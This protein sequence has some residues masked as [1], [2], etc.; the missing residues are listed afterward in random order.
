MNKIYNEITVFVGGGSF[1]KDTAVQVCGLSHFPKC[2]QMTILFFRASWLSLELRTWP[3]RN[4]R[5][6]IHSSI[7]LAGSHKTK[8]YWFI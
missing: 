6:R 5:W 4:R 2:D 3:T 7:E 8:K 1:V